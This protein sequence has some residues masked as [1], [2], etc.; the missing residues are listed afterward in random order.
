MRRSPLWLLATALLAACDRASQP[1]EPAAPTPSLAVDPAERTTV[2]RF[3]E[4]FLV[5]DPCFGEVVSVDAH[6]QLVTYMRTD[7]AGGLHLRFSII[8]QGSTVTG[9]TS[10]VVHHLNGA[11]LDGLNSRGDF[12]P[13]PPPFPIE[14]TFVLIQN[15]TSPGAAPHD[16]NPTPLHNERFHEV[17]HVTVNANGEITVERDQFDFVCK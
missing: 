1:V 8:D 12:I 5:D 14:E 4:T 9:L 3:D 2:T 15:L 7:A 16:P 11:V 6:R 17:F 10:G 13:F